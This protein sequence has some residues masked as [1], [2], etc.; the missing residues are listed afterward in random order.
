[1]D[2]RLTHGVTPDAIQDRAELNE[3]R[4]QNGRMGM[5]LNS[6]RGVPTYR[7]ISAFDWDVAPLPQ[8][9]Q[10]AGIL[11]ADAYC[12]AAASGAK[13][14]AWQFIEFANSVEGQTIIARSGR[15]VPSLKA[16]AESPAFLDPEAKP[17]RSRVFLDDIPHIKRVPTMDTWVDIEDTASQELERVWFGQITLDEAIP[18]I[19]ERTR[20]FFAR[21]SSEQNN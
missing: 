19:N 8:G 21:H 17:Q 10:R 7:A 6:R 11:H 3:S 4:F 9:E 16:V 13:D 1:M 2:L 14:V 20:E 12:M 15:T 18:I 5:Y